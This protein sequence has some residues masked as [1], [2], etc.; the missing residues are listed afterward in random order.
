MLAVTTLTQCSVELSR[1]L[2]G[3]HWVN[4]SGGWKGDLTK[5]SKNV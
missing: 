1:L 4:K 3:I 5:D 2:H